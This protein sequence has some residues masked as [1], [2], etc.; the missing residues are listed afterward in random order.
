[1]FFSDLHVE[2]LS[3]GVLEPGESLVAKTVARYRPWWALGFVDREYLVLATDRRLVLLDHRA[4]F[5]GL[6]WPT[7]LFAVDSIPWA[8]VQE[9]KVKGL[10]KK[11][12]RV[13]GQ[14]ERGPVKLS[15]KLSGWPFGPLLAMKGN[16]QGAKNVAQAFQAAAQ[17]AHA[18]G[19]A[20]GYGQPMLQ[21]AAPQMLMASHQAMPV[22]NAPGYSSYA[23]P[24]PQSHGAVPPPP[25]GAPLSPTNPWSKVS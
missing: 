24:A 5:F 2:L 21:Q 4:G 1:M 12:L 13:I 20:S 17:G 16:I 11:K 8:Q 18:L 6:I 19:P 9:A 23:P 25:P 15:M 14:G 10:F 3:R 22:Q 7:R